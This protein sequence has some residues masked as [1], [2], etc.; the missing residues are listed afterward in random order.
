MVP[1]LEVLPVSKMGGSGFVDVAVE[2]NARSGGSGE[3]SQLELA[4]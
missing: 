2:D 1:K 3:A 4:E